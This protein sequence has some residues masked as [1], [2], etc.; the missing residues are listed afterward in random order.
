MHAPDASSSS[1]Q[2]DG[3]FQLQQ[4]FLA[5]DDQ[6]A[7]VC[8]SAAV[9]IPYQ[10]LDCSAHG[11]MSPLGPQA[12]HLSPMMAMSPLVPQLPHLGSSPGHMQLGYGSPAHAGSSNWAPPLGP[13]LGSSPGHMQPGYRSP[14]CAGS[15]SSP[16]GSQ[17]QH[18]SPMIAMSP[19]GSQPQH[20]SSVMH[21][22]SMAMHSPQPCQRTW[23]EAAR[24]SSSAP[25]SFDA[26]AAEATCTLF[27]PGCAPPPPPPPRA[28]PPPPP[29][30]RA[31]DPFSASSDPGTTGRHDFGVAWPL[32][33][34]QDGFRGQHR[35]TSSNPSSACF[36]PQGMACTGLHSPAQCAGSHQLV[37]VAG[38]TALLVA[39]SAAG[40]GS[41]LP[42][43]KPP[44]RHDNMQAASRHEHQAAFSS[45]TPDDGSQGYSLPL[46]PFAFSP[47]ATVKAGISP[48]AVLLPDI[49]QSSSS[50]DGVAEIWN[51]PCPAWHA[52]SSQQ[53]PA[54]DGL[55]APAATQTARPTLA[56]SRLSRNSSDTGSSHSWGSGISRKSSFSTVAP[57]LSRLSSSSASG[58]VS[59]PTPLAPAN[60]GPAAPSV[61]HGG[62]PLCQ[63][64][65]MEMHDADCSAYCLGG[66][67]EPHKMW[68][69][70][71]VHRYVGTTLFVASPATCL[72]QCTPMEA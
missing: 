33:P 11:Y 28:V 30:A 16:L 10:H 32:Q 60:G 17:L 72:L 57:P 66:A 20:L 50:L 38:V 15:A 61:Q 5:S 27:V 67:L 14:A 4:G 62:I 53:P 29:P 42:G 26:G 43:P 1:Q 59:T 63:L 34:L 58:S 18:L 7:T 31:C 13:Q 56:G 71:G 23:A 64:M 12:Q 70:V 6:H 68:F 44:A 48:L 35:R 69:G 24:F 65:F 2:L 45:D 19:L 40:A 36:S 54:T 22:S 49:N 52:M 25:S 39:T 37:P 51:K 46:D 9:D 55:P 47:P 41:A 3:L 8:G 21:A